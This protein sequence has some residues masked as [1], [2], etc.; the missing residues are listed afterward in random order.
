MKTFSFIN[1][2]SSYSLTICLS[3]PV[4]NISFSYP[5]RDYKVISDLSFKINKG[6]S[7]GIIG[8]SG[9]GKTTLVDIII[10]IISK[11]KGD[12]YIDDV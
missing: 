1:L 10:G 6:D 11:Q 4:N 7:V 2:E 8:P 9:S 3:F 5:T 12:I